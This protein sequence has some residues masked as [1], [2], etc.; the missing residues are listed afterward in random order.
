[1]SAAVISAHRRL[2]GPGLVGADQLLGR[3]AR[4]RRG[5]L[6]VLAD[7]DA[8][9]ARHAPVE[10]VAAQHLAHH[11]V[12]VLGVL[13]GLRADRLAEGGVVGEAEDGDPLE[14]LVLQRLQELGAH[15]DEALDQGVARV[16]LLGR[17]ERAVEVV[18][19]VDELEEEL[20]AALV[21]LALDVA[22]DALAEALVLGLDLA[23]GG[24]DLGQPVLGEPGPALEVLHGSRLGRGLQHGLGRLLRLAVALWPVGVV[25]GIL[26]HG[27]PP[28]R[29]NGL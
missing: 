21:E 28:G 1:M 15:E 18:Q 6:A 16:G 19:D 29:I 8:R 11:D 2:R 22:G 23:V 9:G 5:P 24:Q 12:V 13:D 20:L 7:D 26:V 25:D 4:R 3:P 14:P 27:A 17:L 10:A